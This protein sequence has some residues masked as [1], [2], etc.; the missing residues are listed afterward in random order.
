MKANAMNINWRSPANRSEWGTCLTAALALTLAGCQTPQQHAKEES[1]QRWNKARAA[2]K[3]KLASDQFVAGNVKAAAGE[4]A[5]ARQ[6]DPANANWAALQA[7]IW[8]AEGNT[9]AAADLLEHTSLEGPAQAEIEYLRGIVYQQQQRWDEALAAFARAAELDAGEVAYVVAAVQV[10]LQLGQ[11]QPALQCLEA[12][13]TKFGWTNAYQAA[14]AECYESCGDWTAAATAWRRVAQAVDGDAG[15]RERL[16]EAQCRAGRY[17][18][19]IP[20]LQEILTTAPQ[21]E[22]RAVRLRLAEAYLATG[23]ATA[24]CAETQAILK[25]EPEHAP[26]L[27]LLAQAWAMAGDTGA[28]LRSARR[29]SAARSAEHLRPGTG[30]RVGMA[31]RRQAGGPAAGEPAA[32][33]GARERGGRTYSGGRRELVPRANAGR[34]QTLPLEA[35]AQRKSRPS[36]TGSRI[37]QVLAAGAAHGFFCAVTPLFT[38]PSSTC[39]MLFPSHQWSLYWA[40]THPW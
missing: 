7:R 8:L 38:L 13:A 37:P 3:A 9:A 24:A 25:A 26:A 17:A 16:A 34:C 30:R 20:V 36:R 40:G 21:Q 15:V 19:A 11:P 23:Q 35:R 32:R 2:V 33:A 1:A 18:D 14:L 31:G 39:C 29:R 6:L 27:L 4:L 12:S 28:A 10:W 5:E 22:Q